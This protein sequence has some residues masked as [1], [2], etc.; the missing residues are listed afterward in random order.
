MNLNFPGDVQLG[1]GSLKGL[2]RKLKSLG[3]KRPLLVTDPAM[4]KLGLVDRVQEQAAASAGP[5]PV[6][7]RCVE[8]PRSREVTEAAD[9]FKAA[10]CDG[11]IALGGGSVI[12][13]AKG[14]RV[15]AS[16]GGSILDYDMLKGGIKKIGPDLP[17]LI[18]IPTTAGSGSEATLGAVIIDPEIKF[19]VLIFSP[20]L[21]STCALL[22]P[23]LTVT[24]PPALTAATGLDALVHALEAFTS[25]ADNA[26]ADGLSRAAFGLIGP[27]L[28]RA[29]G[30]GDDLAARE[31]MMLASLM[32][33]L[34]FAAKGL[35]AVHALAHQL[36]SHFGL[37]HGLANALMLPPVVAFNLEAAGD[38]YLAAAQEM[39]LGATTPDETVGA[40][41]DFARNLGL[42]GRL[43]DYGVAERSLA[44]MADSAAKDL[45][46]RSNPRPCGREEL[47]ALYREVL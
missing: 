19:K 10:G 5:L 34:A 35:G 38:K 8:N 45:S 25:P 30:H 42:G 23:E 4:T 40:F 32:G 37:A 16:G 9:A 6:F 24:M 15:V 26:L 20:Y 22:D 43:A 13:V 27:N 41:R 11:V 3:L 33:G 46:L 18:A 14:V 17:P 31:K 36:S 28:P 29:V 2:G 39:G 1:P 21:V 44:K 7:D 47:E 12:D